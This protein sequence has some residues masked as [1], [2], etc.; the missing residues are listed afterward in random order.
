MADEDVDLELDQ[1][2][3]ADAG[4]A[5]AGEAP[6]A[7]DGILRGAATDAIAHL[8]GYDKLVYD[9]LQVIAGLVPMATKD[10]VVPEDVG[11]ENR[12]EY[13]AWLLT[14][15]ATGLGR[16]PDLGAILLDERVVPFLIEN[17][18]G[19]R[20]AARDIRRR[21]ARRI[22]WEFCAPAQQQFARKAKE[23][24]FVKTEY[25]RQPAQRSAWTAWDKGRK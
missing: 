25:V 7:A 19:D 2:L 16:R 3:D 24:S 21:L 1:D 23:E 8:P 13:F 22:V 12:A 9:Q 10:G 5:P 11:F 17:E 14:V 18:L 20:P 4:E 15:F 6:G